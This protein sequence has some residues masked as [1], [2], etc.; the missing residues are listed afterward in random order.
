[1]ELGKLIATVLIIQIIAILGAWGFSK[2]SAKIGN[3]YALQIM[4]V[5]WIGI[6]TAAYFVQTDMQFYFLAA[7]VGTVMGGIQSMSRSTFAKL[8]PD[9]TKET[10]SYFSFYDVAEKMA[11]VLGTFAFGFIN[12]LTGNMRSSV[13]AL[14]VFFIIAGFLFMFI[15]NFKEKHP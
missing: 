8:I 10:A 1:M 2:V 4:I 13:L 15:P 5:V 12:N 7:V 6:T 14:L 9:G 11:T 3:I